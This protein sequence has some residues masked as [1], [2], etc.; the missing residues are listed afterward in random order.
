MSSSSAS[1]Q[2]S[3]SG[4][5]AKKRVN[6]RTAQGEAQKARTRAHIIRTAVP[7][8]AKYGP[9]L[10]VIEDFAKAADISRGT[11]YNYFPN[12]QVLLEACL[13]DL[14]DGLINLIGPVVEN[15]PNPIIRLATAA[16][17]FYR[18]AS[19]EPVFRALL[20]SVSHVGTLAAQQ[21]TD[22]LVE[23]FE[24]GLIA[25]KDLELAQAMAFG[26][27]VHA[28]RSPHPS[29]TQEGRAEEVVYA[30]LVGLQVPPALIRQA[31][32][33]PLPPI[34]SNDWLQGNP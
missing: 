28:L 13:S 15:E 32:D 10:P 11:F 22:D 20:G 9:H 5:S 19:Q 34:E 7:L 24:Q 16:R 12:T 23:A 14:F 30:M 17:L 4:P 2:P 29:T 31:L 18:K 26:F 27:M 6:P 3:K 21:G 1:P 33:V 25:I 8:F